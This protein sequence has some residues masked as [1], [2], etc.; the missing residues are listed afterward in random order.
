M[1]TIGEVS[2]VVQDSQ[3]QVVIKDT[4]SLVL[5]VSAVDQKIISMVSDHCGFMYNTCRS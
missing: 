3:I 1:M 4:V 2:V 5:E